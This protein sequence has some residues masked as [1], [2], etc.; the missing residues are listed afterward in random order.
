MFNKLEFIFSTD[1]ISIVHH[2]CMVRFKIPCL[3]QNFS[4]NFY[5]HLFSPSEKEYELMQWL[6]LDEMTGTGH[7]LISSQLLKG[8]NRRF[9]QPGVAGLFRWPRF[10]SYSVNQLSLK[11]TLFCPL[12]K[13]NR[14]FSQNVSLETFPHQLLL[15]LLFWDNKQI[16]S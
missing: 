10:L 16:G 4:F 7:H 6:D 11:G 3:I 2:I 14:N 8:Y 12:L 13:V 1:I 9:S 15:S 5:M